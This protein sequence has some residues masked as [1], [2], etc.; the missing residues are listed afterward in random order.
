MASPDALVGRTIAG[1]FVVEAH[2]G[3]GAMGAVYRARQVALEKTVAIKVL[4][5][6]HAGESQFVTRFHR[7]AK[8]ASRLN[9]PNSIQVIDF[10]EE[11][12]G[13]LY[14]AMEY[15][16]GRSLHRVLKED[17][18]LPPARIADILM[19]ALAALA[20][21]HDMSVVHR[22]LKPEN[23]IV[24]RGADDDGRFK[25]VIKVCDFGIAKI[26]DTRA[27]R[28][29]GG[30][31]SAAPVT[32]AG[33]IIGT[34][35]YMSPEQGRGEKL[36]PRSDLYSVGVILFEMLTGQLP[37]EAE[38]AIGVLLRHVS[39][40]PRKPSELAPG[41]DPNLEAI[42]LRALEKSRDARFSGAREMRTALRAALDS[43]AWA[44][45]GKDLPS[46]QVLTA[47]PAGGSAA[48]V[49][50]TRPPAVSSATDDAGIK[51][52]FS[53]TAA[54]I[55][56]SAR[57]RGAMLLGVSVGVAAVAA[58]LLLVR[59]ARHDRASMP[60]SATSGSAQS[61]PVATLVPE[62]MP[63]D[64]PPLQDPAVGSF[65]AG[66]SAS[67]HASHGPPS[68]AAPTV[69]APMPVT[70]AAASVV[71][72]AQASVSVATPTVPAAS[73]PPAAAADTSFDPERAYVEV[74]LIN[75]QGVR[76]RAVR[77]AL[78]G[79]GLG[80]CYRRALQA[81]GSRET[82]VATLSLSFDESGAMR[83]AIVTG[84]DFLPGL[85]RCLQGAAAGASVPGSQVD[86]GGG[87]ADVTLSF[88]AP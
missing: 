60:S 66:A 88:K 1:K 4:H 29:Q 3:S 9:H 84:A 25:D 87:T 75:A 39:E 56:R 21:A 35:E 43:T 22:D 7:E 10:G 33:L 62:Q 82:G 11:P 78:H 72:P 50:M 49:E 36:D 81:R 37:F 64:I 30:H 42:C 86:K 31:D 32:T 74:G 44:P 61:V 71:V 13:L 16:D 41:V 47:A 38:N 26:T 79:T 58:A 2:I 12:D 8:A 15:L 83:G 68:K 52:T 48:T 55:P 51:P 45:G 17:G 65:H 85:T 76:E 19:Q 73:P 5:G 77:A 6:E 53:G 54:G 28:S 14:I 70:P 59:S 23:I 69:V 24:L 40:A 18:R 67:P 63:G 34:P 57:R 46:V 80:P 27:Y 20:V